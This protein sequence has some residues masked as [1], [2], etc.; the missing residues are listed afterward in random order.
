MDESVHPNSYVCPIACY[1]GQRLQ[2]IHGVGN[3]DILCDD[4]DDSLLG[5]L[6]DDLDLVARNKIPSNIT[7]Q[8]NVVPPI[9]S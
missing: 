7:S 9:E 2:N 1:D 8:S 5:H 3:D 4:L 6:F